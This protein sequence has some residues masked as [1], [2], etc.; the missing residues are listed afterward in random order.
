MASLQAKLIMK[1]MKQQPKFEIPPIEE[2]EEAR[3]QL[4]AA[5]NRLPVKKGVVFTTG[6]LA[7]VTV[8][9]AEPEKCKSDDI[10]FYIHGGGYIYGTCSS[11]RSYV[12]YLANSTGLRVYSISYRLAPEHKAPAGAEDCFAVYQALL[13]KYPDSKIALLGE[14]GGGTMVLVTTLMARDKGVRLPVCVTAYAPC[15]NVADPLPSR[16]KNE[17]TDISVSG[18]AILQLTEIYAGG[19][20]PRDPYISP[21]FGNYTGFPPLFLIVDDGEVLFDDS[22]QVAAAARKAGV[23]LTYQIKHGLF[24]TYEVLGDMFP[25]AKEAMRDTVTFIYKHMELS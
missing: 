13:E 23:D 11:T 19:K 6:Q 25:E 18:K 5:N 20:D 3:R 7:G 1:M 21:A 4:E 24:H 10:I 9:L 12:S 22:E 15:A 2:L 14:S 16:T 8:E 17:E